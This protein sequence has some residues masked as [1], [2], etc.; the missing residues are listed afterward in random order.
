MSKVRY[1]FFVAS[2]DFL[3]YQEPIEEVLRERMRHYHTIKK[4]VDFFLTTNLDFLDSLDIKNSLIT[5]SAAIVSL[6]PQF[7]TWL[8][9]RV[10]Y[11]I[12]GSFIGS[13]INKYPSLL[14][15]N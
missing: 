5:P 12:K 6:N 4:N 11:G 8:K 10:Q 7:I 14:F 13:S 3:L 9:L 15:S 2:K 1:Y